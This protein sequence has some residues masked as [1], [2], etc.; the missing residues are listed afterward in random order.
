MGGQC[1]AT[2]ANKMTNDNMAPAMQTQQT[3]KLESATKAKESNELFDS[4]KASFSTDFS[5]D[6]ADT[7]AEMIDSKGSRGSGSG[8]F[9]K[10]R[11][12][13]ITIPQDSNAEKNPNFKTPVGEV[14]GSY[15]SGAP[16]PAHA[17][18]DDND[19]DD[20]ESEMMVMQPSDSMSSMGS[21]MMR[22]DSNAALSQT[23]S[24]Q[25][26]HELNKDISK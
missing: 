3:R 19:I 5:R 17:A 1:C 11:G 10:Q 8:S 12:L 9:A 15:D 26:I 4:A 23:S 22:M 20:A 13:S 7:Y 16:N 21:Q 18:Y 6:R 2:E 25:N 14:V 24:F